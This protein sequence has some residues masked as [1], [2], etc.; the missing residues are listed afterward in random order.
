MHVEATYL[1]LYVDISHTLREDLTRQ[2][3]NKE[4]DQKL[5]HVPRVLDF[6]ETKRMSYKHAR[7]YIETSSILEILKTILDRY[8]RYEA[9]LKYPGEWGERAFRGWLVYEVFH[10][11]LKWPISN[12]VFGERF[13]VLLVDNAVKPVIYVETKRPKRGLIDLENFAARIPSYN[14][15]EYAVL[16]NGYE[17]LRRDIVRKKDEKASLRNNNDKWKTFLQP[18]QATNY[19][20]GEVK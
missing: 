1:I 20:Y 19:L 14:T 12:I 10:G 15:L 5:L 4:I 11:K 9:Y 13:D 16:A 7:E 6:G 17:W 18:L 2:K 3:Q 8:K